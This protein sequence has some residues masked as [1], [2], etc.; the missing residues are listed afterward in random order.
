MLV[1]TYGE[2]LHIVFNNMK[3]FWSIRWQSGPGCSKHG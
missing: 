2:P 3:H 1:Y